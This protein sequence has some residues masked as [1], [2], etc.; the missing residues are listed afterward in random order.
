MPYFMDRHDIPDATPADVAHAHLQDL[1]VQDRY[2]VRYLSYWF[3]YDRH[4]AFCLVDAPNEQQALAVHA[5]SHGLLP[6]KIIPVDRNTVEMFLGRIADPA[7]TGFATSAFRVIMFTDMAGSTEL[8]QQLGDDTA[9]ALLRRHDSILRT[10]LE[11]HR[12]SEVK[13]TGDGIMVS[14]ASA[15]DALGCAIAMQR[16]IAAHNAAGTSPQFQVRIGL[17][18]GEPVTEGGDMF[19]AAVQ[20]AA[21]LCS[22]AAPGEICLS[23]ALSELAIGKRFLFTAPREVTLKGFGHPVRAVRLQW[24]DI[25]HAV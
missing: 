12:G 10:A 8:T 14:F 15:T 25:P 20:L 2:G 24:D 5:A 11:A 17:A 19:G 6:S 7:D 13:H 18:A 22:A 3:D 4:S 16:A 23:E 1:E 21:R 9:M